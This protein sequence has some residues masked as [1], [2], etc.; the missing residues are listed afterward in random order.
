M[1]IR[2]PNFW[3]KSIRSR[4]Y[5][6]AFFPLLFLIFPHYQAFADESV[7]DAVKAA[8]LFKFTSYVE[9]PP[10]AFVSPISPL[11]ICLVGS[12]DQF[13]TTLNKIVQGE[14]I[15]G[16]RILVSQVKPDEKLSGCQILFIGS[17]D[18]QRS[19]AILE[20]VRGTPILTVSNNQSDGIIGFLIQNNRVRFNIDAALA[21][22][23][24]LAISSRLMSLAI[25]VKRR[26]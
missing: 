13:N 12:S 4:R 9:W 18:G 19:A 26:E 16:R 22:D 14:N 10:N 8:F 7:E 21:A 3:W 11:N 20:S 1:K 2:F 5:I 23:N 15:D 25:N 6:C 17:S 24:G